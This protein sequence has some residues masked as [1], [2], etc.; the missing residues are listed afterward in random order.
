MCKNMHIA[1]YGEVFTAG[2]RIDTLEKNAPLAPVG[3]LRQESGLA[4]LQFQ[5]LGNDRCQALFRPFACLAGKNSVHLN[6]KL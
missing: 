6:P 1:I 3:S 4:H 5:G 2:F